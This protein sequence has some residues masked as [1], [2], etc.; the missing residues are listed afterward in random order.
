MSDCGPD[1]AAATLLD[2]MEHTQSPGG[3]T[4]KSRG[5]AVLA[6]LAA[7]M[8]AG[9]VAGA[10]AAGTNGIA[11][12]NIVYAG[13]DPTDG[14]SDIYV[15]K[16]DGSAT[17]NITDDESSRKDLSPELSRDGSKIVFTRQ[18]TN[19]VSQLMVVNADG[20][21]LTD[22]TPTNIEKQS[23]VE[24]SWSP[25]GNQV[26]YS[27]NADGNYEL[28]T[29]KVG[30]ASATRLTST[31]WPIQNLDPVWSPSGKAIAF[32]RSGLSLTSAA[33]G[34]FQIRLDGTAATRLTRAIDG[35]GDVS[36][37]YSP[38]GSR[39]AFSSDRAGNHDIYIL[40][41]A[42]FT[43]AKMTATKDRDVDPTFAPDGSALAFVSDRSGA[44]EIW[45]QNLLTLTPGPS[46]A[47]QLTSDGAPKSHPSW[48]PD[49]AQPLPLP[50]ATTGPQPL[51][52]AAVAPPAA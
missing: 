18:F 7:F 50:A 43:V 30:N 46:A 14:M 38:D 37:D 15:M 27:S 42:R 47:V 11:G 2:D 39:I 23:I 19:G 20:S 16:A 41:L 49:A 6:A 21:G 12:G 24:P 29:L 22:V 1:Q 31:K 48:G 25:D 4:M 33:A 9:V 36:P 40:D 28:Y 8:V 26:V 44:T 13:I 34:L 10:G 45:A 51:P 35:E 5:I 17:A 32:S 52:P 3:S